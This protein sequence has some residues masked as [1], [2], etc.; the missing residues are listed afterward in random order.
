MLAEFTK[1]KSIMIVF[2]SKDSDWNCCI[3]EARD[4]FV[5][6]ISKIAQFQKVKLI[7]DNKKETKTYFQNI[8]NIEFIQIKSNDTWI[9]DFGVIS[10]C[11]DNKIIYKDF[12]FN[13][14]GEKFDYL[15]D[16]S[17]NQK[18]F[19]TAKIDFILE[20]GSV[21]SNGQGLLLT[22]KRCLLNKNRNNLTQK[23][24]TNQLIKHLNIKEVLWL[25][26]GYLDGD[27]TDGHI[28]T[29]ARFVDKDTLMYVECEDKSYKYHKELNL[30]KK[31]LQSFKQIKKLIALPWV[32][33]KFDKD[34][35][36][37]P[38]TYANFLITNQAVFV[39]Q[40]NDKN[41]K[42]AT[43]II[44]SFFKEKTIIPIDSRVFIRQGGSLHCLSMQL[45]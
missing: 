31:Q 41:D 39:P 38:C 14:W 27:D 3:N 18:L 36:I 24:T 34:G 8:Q 40:Y 10:V 28:D 33:D 21:E 2:P 32:S 7:S 17:L 42:K 37:M 26:Y 12:I 1:Q 30:M 19:N 6:F 9:R 25:D 43:D 15:L 35:N 45:Y 16:N 23:Q 22:T 44:S 4:S 13:G 20:G 29:L 5:E 11:E